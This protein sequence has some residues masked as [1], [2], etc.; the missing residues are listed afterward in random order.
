[1]KNY[2]RIY[3]F[4]FKTSIP[5]L[6]VLIILT[7]FLFRNLGTNSLQAWDESRYAINALEMNERGDY[8]NYYYAGQPDQWIGKPPLYMWSVALSYK[9]FGTNEFALRFPSALCALL[10]FVTLYFILR[11]YRSRAF[12]LTAC[13]LLGSVTAIIGRHVGRTGEMDAMLSL[14]LL[15]AAGS[16]LMA[17]DFGKKTFLTLC[18]IALGLAFYAKGTPAFMLLPIWAIYALWRKKTRFLL[19]SIHLYAGL[20]I[21][22]AFI[23]SWY[24]L[25]IK[26]GNT[27]P[28]RQYGGSNAWENLFGYDTVTRITNAPNDLSSTKL[29]FIMHYFDVRFNIWNYLFYAA[30]IYFIISSIR[31]KLLIRNR[32]SLQLFSISSWIFLGTLLVFSTDKHD[33]YLA[34][35]ASFIAINGTALIFFVSKKEKW[36]LI[37]ITLVLIVTLTRQAVQIN[38]G[39]KYSSFYTE[40]L[41]PALQK[42]ELILVGLPS[43]NDLVYAR[44]RNN[45]IRITDSL[46]SS[47]IVK[48]NQK[49]YTRD[50][51]VKSSPLLQNDFNVI[52][53]N[54]EWLLLKYL[55]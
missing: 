48:K 55:K 10:I 41:E 38:Q 17:V 34:P 35:V 39:D 36:L 13:L 2:I 12:A 20:L 9:I 21:F 43:Q 50:L 49:I 29:T 53:R 26:Y 32:K 42:E 1:M 24:F 14:F 7:F 47:D 11:K 5:E 22:A 30:F 15:I 46:I 54:G 45:K 23:F 27:F 33:W 8:I 28:D 16:F 18:G 25:I 31:K 6:V 37:P 19:K 4:L 44:F 3:R 52:A 40:F 51:N